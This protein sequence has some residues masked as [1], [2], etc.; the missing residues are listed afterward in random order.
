MFS[1]SFETQYCFLAI[2]SYLN[3]ENKITNGYKITAFTALSQLFLSVLI[4]VPFYLLFNGSPNLLLNYRA[5]TQNSVFEVM[6][7]FFFG[8]IGFFLIP[9]KLFNAKEFVLQLYDELRFKGV[10]NKVQ[11]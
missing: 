9:I 2:F 6:L 5:Y 3:K 7:F 10:S 4:L 11:D 8:P 1:L